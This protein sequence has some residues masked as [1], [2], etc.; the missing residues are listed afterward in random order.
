MIISIINGGFA[1]QL[2]RYACAYATAKKYNQELIIIVQTTNVGTDPFQLGEFKIEYSELYIAENHIQKVMLLEQWKKRYRLKEVKEDE[3]LSVMSLEVFS[4]Y[5]GVILY[6]TYQNA[7]FFKDYI[8]ELRSIFYFEKETFFLT[9]FREEI[10]EKQ[11]VAIHVRRGDFLTYDALCRGMEFY[12]AAMCV[13]EDKIGYG[14]AEYYIFSDD[15]DFVRSYFGR[16]KRIH[17]IQVYGDYR[18]AVEEFLALSLCNHRILTVAS[19]FSRM[20]DALNTNRSGYAIYEDMG[21]STMVYPREN[22]LYLNQQ[23]VAALA[24]YYAP[25]FERDLTAEKILSE[26]E[27]LNLNLSELIRFSIDSRDVKKESE[28]AFRIRK[29]ELLNDSGQYAEA[30]GQTRKLWEVTVGTKWE[31]RMHELYWKCLYE[32][33]YRAESMIEAS[34]LSDRQEELACHYDLGEQN[35]IKELKKSMKNGEIVIVPA[36]SFDPNEFEDMVHVGMILRRLGHQVTFMFWE[37]EPESIYYQPYSKTLREGNFFEDVMGHNSQCRMINLTQREKEFG[38]LHIFFDRYFRNKERVVLMAKQKKVLFAAKESDCSK[39]IT[40]VFWDYTNIFDLGTYKGLLPQNYG[41]CVGEQEITEEEI[42]ECYEIS[43]Y[44]ITFD[45]QR[46]TE[47]SV[48]T[49]KED[50]QQFFH[51]KKSRLVADYYRIAP[52]MLE[53]AFDIILKI[54]NKCIPDDESGEKNEKLLHKKHDMEESGT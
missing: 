6:G 41:I 25:L 1:N 46:Q 36:R 49:L 44:C 24:G 40:T 4:Q 45:W 9:K 48:V 51:L 5:E 8:E 2:Y 53:N 43:D 30:L 28:L 26:Q 47:E 38:S 21:F 54:I 31:A 39:K 3:Y 23:M 14:Q 7:V 52:V 16:N 50:W 20:A 10:A 18:E 22:L 33:G 34:F 19:S 37:P 29:I 17:Y 27:I 35:L 11:S 12:R 42:T 32:C 13:M 15:K